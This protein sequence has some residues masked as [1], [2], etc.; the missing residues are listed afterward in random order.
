MKAAVFGASGYTGQV[1]VSLLLRHPAVEKLFLVRQEEAGSFQQFSPLFPDI[2]F[3]REK[4]AEKAE[5]FFLCLPD[6]ESQKRVPKLLAQKKRIID[7]SGDYRVSAA[8]HRK[9]YGVKRGDDASFRKRVY[10]LPELF[11]QA[12]AQAGLV[13]NPGCYATA[14]LL[15]LYPLVSSGVVKRGPF[16]VDAKSGASGLGRK[17]AVHSHFVEVNESILPYNPLAHDQ[18]PEIEET[19][20]QATHRKIQVN[21]V[22]HLLSQSQGILASVYAGAEAKPPDLPALYR[23][24][25]AGAPFVKVLERLPKTQWVVQTPYCLI[26]PLYDPRTKTVKVFS[27]LDNLYKGAA[28]QA[29]ESFNLM[30]GLPQEAGLSSSSKS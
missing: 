23:E 3:C 1:L 12:I 6:G 5:V 20:A 8:A 16:F 27:A 17:A 15:A 7:F 13:A 21:F 30:L 14:A 24:V 26:A 28:S 29:V 2:P 19:L 11:A 9:Y 10:G 25:Y 4:V 22:P 18:I